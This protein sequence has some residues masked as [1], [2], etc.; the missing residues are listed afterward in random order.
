[1][2][3]GPQGQYRPRDAA[4][5]AVAVMKIA[6]GELTE[7]DVKR[8]VIE[9]GDEEDCEDL[10]VQEVDRQAIAEPPPSEPY[11]VDES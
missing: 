1:M 7:E 2:P 6:T 9:L 4:S 8:Q 5:R 11:G 10:P 3:I